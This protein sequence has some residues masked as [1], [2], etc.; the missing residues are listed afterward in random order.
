MCIIITGTAHNLRGVL[1]NTPGLIESICELNPH[2]LGL[3]YYDPQQGCTVA[4]KTLPESVWQAWGFL[5]EYLPGAG[6]FQVAIHARFTTHGNTDLDNCH[7]Y[8]IGNGWLM[9]NGV[10]RTGNAAD[11]NKSDTWH[12]INDYLGGDGDLLLTPHGRWLVGGHI[13]C[14]NRFVYLAPQGKMA[15]INK[16]T[17]VKYQKLW[18]SNTYAWDVSLLDP[19]W[20]EQT[21]WNRFGWSGRGR[22]RWQQ[23]DRRPWLEGVHGNDYSYL[24]DDDGDREYEHEYGYD[25]DADGDDDEEDDIT[26][27]ASL[28]TNPK[29]AQSHASRQPLADVWRGLSGRQAARC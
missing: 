6:E 9:H 14:G 20:E 8:P 7:P 28:W 13:G 27:I 2:G 15:T 16:H 26:A 3:M 19:T 5:E 29:A 23:S 21:K 11:K 25:F 17:G 4:R 24:D 22:H 1:L 10:L 18:F 12:Y